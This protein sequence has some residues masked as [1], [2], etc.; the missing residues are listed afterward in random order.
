LVCCVSLSSHFI[1]LSRVKINIESGP[2][3]AARSVSVKDFFDDVSYL[4]NQRLKNN[5]V[6]LEAPE[7]FPSDWI[8]KCKIVPLGQV[9]YNLVSNALDAISEHENPWVRIN[10]EEKGDELEFSVTDCGNGITKEAEEKIFQPFF[11]TKEVGK[12]TGLGLAISQGT[13]EEMGSSLKIDHDC[14]N[15]RFYF[16]I[17]K[18]RQLIKTA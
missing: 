3:K 6:N 14:E 17:K 9:V 5:N 16:R 13:L 10:V 12:G 18:E 4:Y 2:V 15:T 11:T 1:L 8:I 7:E